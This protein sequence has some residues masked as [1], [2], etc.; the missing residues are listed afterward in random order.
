MGSLRTRMEAGTG[1][2]GLVDRIPGIAMHGAATSTPETSDQVPFAPVTC[3]TFFGT[4]SRKP[5]D[6]P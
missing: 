6:E 2:P 3:R 1:R 5:S 4:R